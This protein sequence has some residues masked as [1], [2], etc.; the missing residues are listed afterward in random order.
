MNISFSVTC[1]CD[2]IKM[3][4]LELQPLNIFYDKTATV[5]GGKS[6]YQSGNYYLFLNTDINKWLISTSTDTTA[7]FTTNEVIFYITA[8]CLQIEVM[9]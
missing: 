4:N 1:A 5:V 8:F 9:S 2:K 6:V 7:A 3:D